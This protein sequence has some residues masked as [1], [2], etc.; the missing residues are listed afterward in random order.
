[1][2]PTQCYAELLAA[3]AAGDDDTMIQHALNL[4]EW[5]QKGGFPP[6]DVLLANVQLVLTEVLGPEKAK[7]GSR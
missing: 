4:R 3:R 2:D 5:L 6:Q 1:M 7:E